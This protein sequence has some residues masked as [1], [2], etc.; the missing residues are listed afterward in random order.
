MG[1][2]R[3]D[4]LEKLYPQLKP[5]QGGLY[6]EEKT[7]A[8]EYM[9]GFN[10]QEKTNEIYG[11]GNAYSFEFRTY[12]PRLGRFMSL[13]PLQS[14]FPN[15]SPYCFA[16]NSVL[17]FTELE[18]AEIKVTGTTANDFV[19][20]LGARTG[21]SLDIGANGYLIYKT[22]IAAISL[23]KTGFVTVTKGSP[24]IAP[25]GT[26]F[27][28]KTLRNLVVNTINGG[29]GITPVE[30]IAM[31]SDEIKSKSSS[32]ADEVAFDQFPGMN[33][34]SPNLDNAVNVTD[35]ENI[36]S[37]PVLQA[38]LI[39]H[40]IEERASSRGLTGQ[41]GYDIG[42]PKGIQV[43]SDIVRESEGVLPGYNVGIVN[44][45]ANQEFGSGM[46]G[47]DLGGGQATGGVFDYGARTF[48]TIVPSKP[49]N[50]SEI[51]GAAK[52]TGK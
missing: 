45:I 25:V 6:I 33:P 4:I 7:R 38:G 34:N 23:D 37:E 51:L 42:H 49:Y 41:A 5:V 13:D 43:E 12:D 8:G 27:V 36:G 14:K 35:F 47:R 15:T 46:S 3:L 9:F 20:M 2:L 40:F 19:T 1:A 18:G 52:V 26:E 50:A 28:S 44:R 10:G 48:I 17:A 24:V 16:M 22:N 32:L 39:G 30:I 11:E 29:I 31:T 21:L